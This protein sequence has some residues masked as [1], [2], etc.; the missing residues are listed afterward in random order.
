[1][2][3]RMT[4]AALR[5]LL[6]LSE[7][8]SQSESC[9][10]AEWNAMQGGTANDLLPRPH[11]YGA[12]ATEVDGIRFDSIAE[13]TRYAE[14]RHLLDAG[15]IVSLEIQPEFPLIVNGVTIGAYRG[16]F[17][18]RDHRGDRVIEDVKGVRTP[19]YRLKKMLLKALYGIDVVE[20]G[21]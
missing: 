9:T 20:V 16:D 5:K 13:A 12:I 3:D 8:G 7:P 14:L 4:S 6:N 11:K 21:T 17:A 10:A 15:E 1:M 2:T 19:V 18:Y